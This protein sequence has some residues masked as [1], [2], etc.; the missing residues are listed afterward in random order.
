MSKS[1]LLK[2]SIAKK[3]WMAFT[4]LFL[5][6]FLVGHLLGNL[7]LFAGGEE[8]R[9]A[10]NEYAYFMQHNP[11][12]KIMSY[13]TYISILFHAI[14]GIMLAVQN[15]KARPVQYA[16]SNAA[17]N[18]SSASRMMAILGSIV[19][20][21]IATHMVHFWAKMH[22]IFGD[23]LNLHTT[24][25]I[26]EN[27]TVGQDPTT[28]APIQKDIS[29]DYVLTTKGDYQQFAYVNP[30][31]NKKEVVFDV[32]DE[33]KLYDK[34]TKLNVGEGYKDLHTSVITFFGKDAQGQ[35]KNEYALFAVLFY[36]LSMAVMGFHL[37][38]GFASAFQTLGLRHPRYT[39]I[40]NTV[41]V[42]FWAVIPAAFAS[43]PAYILFFY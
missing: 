21:F 22:N 5:C 33:T 20:I 38:H 18:S 28:G 39:P 30:F 3:Y 36:V 35:K 31:T 9:R 24:T 41:A 34:K 19:L 26:M 16:M 10:F 12:I 2:S 1:V 14:D 42:L 37:K 32:K 11:L 17:A 25:K 13:V 15:K 40:I 29:V 8:G 4:G 6:L 7:Q 43:I 27:E 23:G